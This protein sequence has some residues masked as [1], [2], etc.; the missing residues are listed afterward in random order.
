M[1]GTGTTERGEMNKTS[2]AT[3]SRV[4]SKKQTVGKKEDNQIWMV[5]PSQLP[6]LSWLQTSLEVRGKYK[7]KAKSSQSSPRRRSSHL[8][9]GC[10]PGTQ[11]AAL[12][13]PAQ[14]PASTLLLLVPPA[15]GVRTADT[16]LLLPYLGMA[17]C[18]Y[19]S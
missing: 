5:P 14:C 7:H 3:Y 15:H 17:I 18:S 6:V 1:D 2:S 9:S 10:S 19:F 16:C 4:S 11:Q 13:Q 8:C 12:Y